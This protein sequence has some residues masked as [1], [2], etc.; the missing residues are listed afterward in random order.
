V[1]FTFEQKQLSCFAASQCTVQQ[2]VLRLRVHQGHWYSRK[3]WVPHATGL[4]CTQVLIN[5]RI[6][7]NQAHL[8]QDL[9]D[10]CQLTVDE[11]RPKPQNPSSPASDDVNDTCVA[12]GSIVSQLPVPKASKNLG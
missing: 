8:H 12:C 6:L 11:V 4:W 7:V 10:L 9:T 2:G 3:D 1:K 5:T